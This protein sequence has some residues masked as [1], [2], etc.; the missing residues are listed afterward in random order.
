MELNKEQEHLLSGKAGRGPQK[1]MEIIIQLAEAQGAENLVRIS[2]AHLMPPD[3]MFFPVISL[4]FSTI[5]TAVAFH[6]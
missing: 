4:F 2:Y 3:V 5:P 1:A 6:T